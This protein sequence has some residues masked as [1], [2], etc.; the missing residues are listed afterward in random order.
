[1][2]TPFLFLGASQAEKVSGS[3]LQPYLSHPW[4]SIKHLVINMVNH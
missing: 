2:A 3:E 1:M 4:K